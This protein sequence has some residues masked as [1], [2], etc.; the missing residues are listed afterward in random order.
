VCE[1]IGRH[2]LTLETDLIAFHETILPLL[3]EVGL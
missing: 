3:K 2:A 1:T